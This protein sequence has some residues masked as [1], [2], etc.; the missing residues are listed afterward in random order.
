MAVAL[1]PIAGAGWQF[2]DNSGAIL[3]GGLL[4]TY[5]AGTTTPLATYQDSNGFVVHTNPIIL[6]SAGRVPTEVWMTAG[7]A[8]K[9][10]LKTS[11]SVSLWTMDNLR[12]INDVSSV[13]WSAI[14]GEPTTLAGYGI[15]DGI[16]AATAAST[17]AP[18]ASPTF[19]GTASAKDEDANTYNIGWRDCPQNAKTISYELLISDRG[20]QILM[21][22]TSLTLTIPANGGGA[23]P[24]AFPLG[25]TIMVVN[26]NSTSLSIAITT[27]TMTLANSTT[28]GTRTLA[29]NGLATLTKV[30][31]SNWL[32]AGTGVT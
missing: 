26:S 27:D 11:A 23:T 21:N 6:D 16:T 4:Y 20:K 7:S 30:G 15:T 10:V 28:T 14:T 22:G 1:S 12:G 3:A 5:A 32:I 29:Q 17:Y 13:A 19:T 2:F 31:T 24:V 8:Y 9:L 18:L 25:T